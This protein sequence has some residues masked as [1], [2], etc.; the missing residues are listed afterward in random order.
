MITIMIHENIILRKKRRG[1]PIKN[2]G[3][4]N[5]GNVFYDLIDLI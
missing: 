3:I 4:F 2:G 5:I 1:F